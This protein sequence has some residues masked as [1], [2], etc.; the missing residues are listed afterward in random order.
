MLSREVCFISSATPRFHMI[1]SASNEWRSYIFCRLGQ[2]EILPP[3]KIKNNLIVFPQDEKESIW[4][5]LP[6]GGGV[7][8]LLLV[9]KD[10]ANF[11]QTHET[12]M[13]GS[14]YRFLVFVNT[15]F[16]REFQK[17]DGM[18]TVMTVVLSLW[19]WQH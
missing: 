12:R 1:G 13:R 17:L 11:T 15:K 7:N 8:S 5:L 10:S 9:F 16:V 4:G 14:D 2:E 6:R 18:F 3:S 19:E